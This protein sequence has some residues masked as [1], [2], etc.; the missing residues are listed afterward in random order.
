MCLFVLLV[1]RIHKIFVMM[2]VFWFDIISKM[3]QEDL[4][5]YYSFSYS[6]VSL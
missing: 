4:F 6:S 1:L 5:Y 3:C 2:K